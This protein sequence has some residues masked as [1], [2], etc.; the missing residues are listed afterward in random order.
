MPAVGASWSE[1]RLLRWLRGLG[2]DARL[3]S[4]PRGHDATTLARMRGRPVVCVD[5]T[6]EGVH[7]APGTRAGDFARKAVARSVSDLAASAARPRAVLLAVGAAPGVAEAYLRRLITAVRRAALAFGAELAG[8]DLACRPGPLA[9]AVTALGEFEGRG[10]PPAR[11]RARSGQHV[12]LTGPVGG[13]GLGRHLRIEPRLEAGR[14]LAERGATALMDVSDG[15]ARD[16]ARLAAS[17]GVRIELDEVPIHADAHRS[18][19]RSGQSALEHALFDGEDHE[20]IACMAPRAA[21]AAFA[22]AGP[23][24]GL[25]V[26]G[27]VRRGSGLYLPDARG[28]WRR[29][30]G[31]GGYVHGA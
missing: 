20:L 15:L 11:H 7:V 29:W 18:A 31:R 8:G 25:C 6:I 28:G 3:A 26:I 5:Q 17:A 9:L 19:R 22:A 24:S 13:S 12:L 4:A 16:L 21:R 30:D 2:I 10:E 23:A 27:R 1:E 14:F